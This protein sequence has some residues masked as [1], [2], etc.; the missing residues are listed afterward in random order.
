ANGAFMS[1]GALSAR[2]EP[3]P[4]RRHGQGKTVEQGRQGRIRLAGGAGE[5]HHVVA[6][7]EAASL[8]DEPRF[9]LPRLASYE[10]WRL[11]RFERRAQ[12]VQLLAM[13]NEYF[14]CN[15]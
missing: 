8:P 9:T 6:L 10:D 7:E 14:C 12:E 1:R 2:I 4:D 13:P 15:L 5:F 3:R 11:A